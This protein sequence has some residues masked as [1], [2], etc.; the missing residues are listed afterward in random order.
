MN[1]GHLYLPSDVVEH[2]CLSDIGSISTGDVYNP[3]DYIPGETIIHNN[4]GADY[5]F[6][7]FAPNGGDPFGVLING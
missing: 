2:D 4:F 6:Q 3:N 7:G 1:E 5:V